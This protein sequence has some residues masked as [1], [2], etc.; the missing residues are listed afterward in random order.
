MSQA[1]DSPVIVL[2]EDRPK[3]GM[4]FQLNLSIYLDARV[5]RVTDL[6]EL[7]KA[8]AGPDGIH[9][10]ITRNTIKGA[11][12]VQKIVDF[13]A[14]SNSPVPVICLGDHKE[15]PGLH[16]VGSD[17]EVKPMLQTAAK[18]LGITAKQMVSKKRAD[19]YEIAPEFLNMLFTFPC[20]I[21]TDGGKGLEK[22]FT[23]GD[24]VPRAK[25][26]KLVKDSRPLVVDA[27]QRLKLAN[28][29]TEQAAKATEDLTSEPGLGTEKKMSLLSA[30]LD[31]VASQFQNAGMDEETIKLANASIK[32]VEKIAE[33]TSSVGNLVKQL[34]ETQGGYRYA[35][36]QL[37]TFLGF[38]VIKMMNWWGDDQRSILS[39]A[40][41][42]H[43]ISLT[44]DE[45]A[46]V[47]NAKMLGD[48][49]GNDPQL[50]ELLNSH[51]QLAARELQNSPEIQPEVVR[52]VIQHHGSPLGK[53]FSYDIA[54][55]D[56]IAKTFILSEEW[57]DY[58][59]DLAQNDKL[60]DNDAKLRELKAIYKD[61]QSAQIIETFR[62]LDPSAFAQDFLRAD[63]VNFAKSL[64]A[65]GGAGSEAESVVV[66]VGGEEPE[67]ER[68][69]G[70]DKAEPEAVTK[71]S[72]VTD[73]V[74]QEEIRVKGSDEKPEPEKETRIKPS[75]EPKLADVAR[76]QGD[77]GDKARKLVA[78]IKEKK[79]NATD[80]EVETLLKAGGVTLT[81]DT[82]KLVADEAAAEEERRF[83]A[84]KRE[85]EKSTKVEGVT[86]HI[87]HEEIKVKG[88]KA[89]EASKQTIKGVTDHIEHEE[90]KLKGEKKDLQ[91]R[92]VTVVKG[93]KP[94][95]LVDRSITVIKADAQEKERELKMKALAGSSD[96]MKAAVSGAL[97]KVTEILTASAGELRK[98]DAEGR[99]AIHYACMSGSVP[100]LKFLLEKGAGLNS[101]DS[102]RR[103]PLFFAALYKHNEAFDFLLEQGAKVN[104][105][106]MGGMT[107]AMIG[108]SSG[109]V[110]ILKTAIEKGV[111]YD[112]KDHAGK[113]ALDYAKQSKNAEAIQYLEALVAAAKAG[114]DK[115]KTEKAEKAE[116]AKAP[117]DKP[118]K[119]A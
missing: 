62:Y 105:Q 3:Q 63:E 107:I 22:V 53:G 57:G 28:A 59:M 51:P 72:G 13:L 73:H 76:V 74:S 89:E 90:I 42:Y 47:R 24:T 103:S 30:S 77:A 29:V 7:K 91:D 116:K 113:T 92:S 86:Q 49:A 114:A 111:K 41:F 71:V 44:S 38:H 18:L 46:M 117:A 2:F 80:E 78:K 5:Q 48:L 8:L 4:V 67:E 32:A 85:K 1:V 88:E 108:A 50:S 16:V 39:Q 10:V 43:D 40:A 64:I 110:H 58:L 31:M 115:E 9:L 101:P 82:V 83:G 23:A 118:D 102:K 12:L 36:C 99:T 94:Q 60:A 37:I 75:R 69:F 65:G 52:V 20:D 68:R 66:P 6:R 84:G 17:N 55:L 93:D 27:Y 14:S 15:L 81:D 54:K 106:S 95:D 112:V 56:P 70:A 87:E 109:N 21:F 11:S 33:S 119:A 34:L 35:H 26:T 96:L 79:P 25:V 98:T 97:D 45:Q 104:Q 19:T 61:E 100:V